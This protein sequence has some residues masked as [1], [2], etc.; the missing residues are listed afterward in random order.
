MSSYQKYFLRK[1]MWYAVTLTVAIFLNFYLPRLVRGN[2]VDTIVGRIAKGMTD[3][4]AIKNMYDNF[5]REFNLGK[6]IWQQFLLYV[7]GLLH[8]DLGTSFTMYPRKIN[9]ILSSALP[10]TIGLQL[11]AIILGWLIGNILGA[12]AAYKKG[13]FDKIIFPATLF[14]SSIPFFILSIILL[15]VF[16]ITLKWFPSGGGYGYTVIPEMSFS[17][18]KSIL[19]HHFLPFM[20]IVLIMIG[21]QGIGMREMALYE[22]NA[23]YV[24]YAKLMGIR[25]SKIIRYVFRNAMLPQITGLAMSLGTMI[26]GAL[27]TEIVFN[28]PGLGTLLFRSIRSLDYPLISACTLL[29]TLT[30]L[31]ANFLVDILYGIID[32]RIKASQSEEVNR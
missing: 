32:P 3:T 23:D 5:Y 19:Y 20:S 2:P 22:L 26:A 13:I 29:I 7:G 28:Y 6:P 8:F 9:D 24:K 17:F 27:I 21:G 25:E 10:W 14:I 15:Y 30:V 1:L 18:F 11:P 12:F 4:D 16:A 31:M